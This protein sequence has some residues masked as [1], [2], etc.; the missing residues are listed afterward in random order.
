MKFVS[1]TISYLIFIA[2]IIV[3]SIQFAQEEGRRELFSN[4]S[5][6]SIF[7][8]NSSK[9]FFDYSK[10]ENF[11]IRVNFTDFHIRSGTPSTLD[12]VINIWIIGNS[13]F[14]S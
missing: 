4:D 12:Y 2:L 14:F 10:N 8:K 11:Q 1:H 9:I 7:P 3:S 5:K 6:I 13:I